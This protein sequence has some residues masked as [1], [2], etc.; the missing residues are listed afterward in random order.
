V[1][2]TEQQPAELFAVKCTANKHLINVYR[3]GEI[4]EGQPS[5]GSGW[6]D[7]KARGKMSRQVNTTIWMHHLGRLPVHARTRLAS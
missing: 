7:K 5:G 3:E 6:F 2:L 1:W 4:E